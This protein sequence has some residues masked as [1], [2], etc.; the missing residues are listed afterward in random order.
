[1][2]DYVYQRKSH[3]SIIDLGGDEEYW[4]LI[5]VDYLLSR[6]VLITL[7]NIKLE[8]SVQNPDLFQRVIGDATSLGHIADRQFDIS[9]SNSLIEHVG[10]WP[11]KRAM[12]SET[13]RIAKCYY[14]QTP[15]LWFPVEPHFMFP[16]YQFLPKGARAS[17]IMSRSRG[18]MQQASSFDDAMDKV[19]GCDLLSSNDIRQL[20]PDATLFR[21]RIAF[22]TKS[23][24]A[25]GGDIPKDLSR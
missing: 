23:L 15:N 3:C 4:N 9:H 19:E 1:M 24:I 7:L 22:L 8:T 20:F 11:K 21:E 5:G 14:L 25:V 6:K 2:I 12:A 13:V 10:S 16:G 18:W 17:L